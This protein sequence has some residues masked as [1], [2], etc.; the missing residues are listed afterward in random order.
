MLIWRLWVQKCI[1]GM[2]PKYQQ[3]GD[4]NV[5]CSDN[6]VLNCSEVVSQMVTET[7]REWIEYTSSPTFLLRLFHGT[8]LQDRHQE[9]KSTV[10]NAYVVFTSIFFL[11]C[12][13]LTVCPKK[14]SPVLPETNEITWDLPRDSTL[15]FPIQ[16][17]F[18][19]HMVVISQFWHF[20]TNF[21]HNTLSLH[22][23][24]CFDFAVVQRLRLQLTA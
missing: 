8:R 22:W 3:F 24:L 5:T 23:S 9:F 13:M 15:F 6:V 16:S 4:K 18:I 14:K 10:C 7:S 19:S 21:G 1:T 12:P 11:K 2:W 20:C 17:L